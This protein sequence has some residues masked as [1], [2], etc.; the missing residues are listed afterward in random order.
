MKIIKETK[1]VDVFKTKTKCGKKEL[2]AS[3]EKRLR[4]NLELHEMF[5]KECKE[6]KSENKKNK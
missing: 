2:K 5:C 6:V 3:S 4:H 1:E